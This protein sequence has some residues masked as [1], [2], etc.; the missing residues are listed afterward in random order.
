MKEERNPSEIS[1]FKELP[2]QAQ[3]RFRGQ[4]EAL[5]PKYY[6]LACRT[7]WKNFGVD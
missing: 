6:A 1:R 3:L 7:K 4:P 5:Q 2:E